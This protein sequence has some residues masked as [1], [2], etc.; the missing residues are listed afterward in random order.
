[1]TESPF[2]REE[3]RLVL[4]AVRS[5]HAARTAA[6]ALMPAISVFAGRHRG[7]ADFRLQAPLVLRV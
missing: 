5:L 1:V 7:A 6:S 3:G 2:I 4:H